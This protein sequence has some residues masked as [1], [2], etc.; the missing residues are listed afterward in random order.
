MRRGWT[1]GSVL[2]HQV[3][4]V[5]FL[6]GLLVLFAS[7]LL[8][9]HLRSKRATLE[10]C[11]LRLIKPAKTGKKTP[12]YLSHHVLPVDKSLKSTNCC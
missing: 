10:S 9:L 11:L 5:A 2:V 4:S 8:L 1:Y 3:G 7:R 12:A 6:H